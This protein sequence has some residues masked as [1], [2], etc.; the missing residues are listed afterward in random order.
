MPAADGAGSPFDRRAF[1]EVCLQL[2]A[3][4][5]LLEAGRRFEP[6]CSKAVVHA[7]RQANVP[8]MARMAVFSL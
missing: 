6:T 8:M 7:A 3:A 1:F 4:E 5:E 2:A